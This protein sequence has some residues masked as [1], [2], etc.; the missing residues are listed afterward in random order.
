MIK[1]DGIYYANEN[2]VPDFGSIRTVKANG[3]LREYE[4]LSDDLEKL[5]KYVKT[6]SSFFAYDTKKVYKFNE[7]DKTWYEL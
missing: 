2:E 3:M 6:G 4:G 1:F 7:S 5:P